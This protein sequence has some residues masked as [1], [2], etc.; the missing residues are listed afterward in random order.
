[1]LVTLL[2][3]FTVIAVVLLAISLTLRWWLGSIFRE[4]DAQR[5]R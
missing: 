4:Y 1:M 2:V 3:G 5:G